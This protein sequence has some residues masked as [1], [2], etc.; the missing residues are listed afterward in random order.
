M[1]ETIENANTPR[2]FVATW[3]CQMNEYDS[4]KMVDVLAKNR[5]ATRVAT[6]E[7]ADIILL[8]TCSIREKAQEK[9]FSQLGRWKPLKDANPNL[10]IGVGGCVASQEGHVIRERAP[11]V[12]MVFGPQ[13]LHR[14][15]QMLDDVA[16]NGAGIVDIA[17]PE[18]DK[19]DAMSAPR[20]EGATAFVSIMEGC[21]KYCSFCVVP[22]TRGEEISRPFDDVILEVAELAEQGVKEI[23][24]L[25]QNV[26]AW[27]GED[28]KGRAQG[29]DGLVRELAKIDALK[30]IRYT[31]SHPNDMSDGLIAAHGDVDKL[32]PFLHLPVQSGNDRILK[33]MNRSH[34]VEGYLRLIDRVRAARPDIALSGDF[35]V[36]FPGETEEEFA[37]TLRIVDAVGYAQCYSFKYSP[38]PGTP[39]ADMDGQIPA[40]VMDDRLVR[41][42]AA[43]N[44]HQVGF[45]A[46]TVGRR[47]TILLERAGRYPGQLIGKTPWLQSVH[48]TA[49]D[50]AIG[51]MIEVDIISAGPNS[52]A[53]EIGRRKAA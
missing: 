47:T 27:T 38:R 48:V 37:D 17:F 51:D 6:P 16:D 12:D 23:T 29:M 46:A 40:D 44:R 22:Y 3:G 24:L 43:I 11:F 31:T 33:A 18:I 7:E 53:G 28:D 41:L 8:N 1:S 42:Q 20:A 45:N 35:I 15:P 5:G 50:Q 30:R 13:T 49:P 26:N 21:S 19:F 25:G 14:L 32:M 34:S 52:L 36:G 39:A 10:V 9:V 4:A 2:V